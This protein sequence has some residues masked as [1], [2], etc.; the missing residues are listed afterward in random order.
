MKDG[1][2]KGGKIDATHLNTMLLS[3]A[4]LGRFLPVDL[5]TTTPMYL[6]DFSLTKPG[7]NNSDQRILFLGKKP[8]I[9]DGLD[10]INAF[11]DV[12]DFDT[13]A[14]RTNAVAGALTVMLRNHWPGGKPIIVVTTTKSH[15]GKDTV[16]SFAKGP[17]KGVS[18]S[19]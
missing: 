2:T 13:V 11:L 12:M 15:A 19:Y 16:I 4:F 3:E 9:A 8:S 6:P 17:V 18:I 7:Y 1:K 14:D 10:T 5:F